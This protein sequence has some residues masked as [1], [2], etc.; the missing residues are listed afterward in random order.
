MAFRRRYRTLSAPPPDEQVTIVEGGPVPPVRPPGPPLAPDRYWWP[1][2]A[3]L[4][5]VLAVG[6][7]L[8]AYFATS[9]GGHK[10]AVVP[11]VVGLQEP[12]AVAKLDSAGLNAKA[13]REFSSKASGTVVA[14]APGSGKQTNKGDTVVLTVSKGPHAAAVPNLVSLSEADAVAQLTKAGLKANVHQVPSGQ[15]PGRVVAQNPVAGTTVDPGST[16]RLNV[17][18]GRVETTTVT[19][20]THTTATHTTTTTQ[21]TT[22]TAQTTVPD[23]VGSGL[24]D[25]VA[26]TRS[27]SLLADSYPVSSDQGG[28]TVVTQSPA[29][30]TS[31]DAGSIVRLNVS[32]GTDRPP[33]PVPDVTGA[34]Q[35][36]ARKALSKTFTVRTVFRTGQ[37]G[38]VLGQLPAA[39]AQAR[40]W[41]QV[42]IYVG[43]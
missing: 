29:A 37:S 23:V 32:T 27:A 40:R 15:R 1:W 22:T 33:L 6:G 8:A 9:G 17:S 4:L 14:Q 12:L 19:T 7:G 41:A 31:V 16:V 30:D 2:L 11:L 3:V 10:K 43:R 18:K 42:I 20:T 21:T 35:A 13:R 36:A 39:G 28:G 25:A 26:E 5:V 24:P 38:I 34:S